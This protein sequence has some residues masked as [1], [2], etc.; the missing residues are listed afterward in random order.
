MTYATAT[1]PFLSMGE[2]VVVGDLKVGDALTSMD[3]KSIRINSMRRVDEKTKV[4]NLQ[5][6]SLGTYIANGVVAHNKEFPYVY[7]PCLDCE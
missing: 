5:I 2:W 7:Y 3:G 1:Q 6:A 4:F